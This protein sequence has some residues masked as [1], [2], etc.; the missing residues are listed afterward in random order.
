LDRYPD[1]SA[2]TL[3]ETPTHFLTLYV[4]LELRQ[5]QNR[6]VDPT[7]GFRHD[8]PTPGFDHRANLPE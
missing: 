6:R 7:V 1:I 2:E 5:S 3:A 4:V 8:L